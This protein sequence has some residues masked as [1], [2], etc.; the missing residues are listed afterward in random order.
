MSHHVRSLLTALLLSLPPAVLPSAAGAEEVIV[1]GYPVGAA[2]HPWAVAVA[3]RAHLGDHRS[4][5]FCG[6]AVVGPRA[7]LTA[8]HCLSPQV[9][10]VDPA[11]IR[12]L[13]VIA[14]RSDLRKDEG[15]EIPVRSLWINPGHDR[16]TNAGDFAVLILSEPL[17]AHHAVPL[18]GEGDPAYAPGTPADV[19]G[20]GDTSGRGSFAMELHSARVRLLADTSCASAYR[21]STAGVFDPESMLCAA[22]W[23][24]GRDACQGDSGGPLV[25]Y[26]R[27]VGLV[28]WGSGC[29]EPGQ[30]GVYSRVSVIADEL[31]AAGLAH[32]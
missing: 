12:D 2:E 16:R 13:T 5:Q 17:P 27:L 4:G 32:R 19:Y 15:R 29:G 31:V 28:S 24:G 1:G 25:A 22:V 10:G 26:G 9:T 6:G 18:A 23:S 7:V 20:W 8:A 30:P 11:D 3:S 14:G 21:D